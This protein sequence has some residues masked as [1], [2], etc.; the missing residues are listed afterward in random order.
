MV[1]AI[2]NTIKD[3]ASKCDPTTLTIPESKAMAAMLGY[4]ARIKAGASG[5][6]LYAL[7]A[8][9]GMPSTHNEATPLALKLVHSLMG[10]KAPTQTSTPKLH[11]AKASG[12]VAKPYTTA[13]H[14]RR[15][16]LRTKL[17]ERFALLCASG[18]GT[19]YDKCEATCRIAVCRD[20]VPLIAIVRGEAASKPAKAPRKR[21]S[22]K[23]ANVKAGSAERMA[24]TETASTTIDTPTN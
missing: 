15:F 19:T 13:A 21:K 16:A 8:V 4:D 12:G 14:P 5:W 1:T 11:Y 10:T 6:Q 22:A 7:T 23:P 20:N 3:I 24:K 2:A 9:H 18:H 17:G